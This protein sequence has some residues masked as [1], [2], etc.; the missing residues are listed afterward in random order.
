[1][2]ID[3]FHVLHKLLRKN[4]KRKMEK[5]LKNYKEQY[6]ENKMLFETVENSLVGWHGYAK[7]ANTYKYRKKIV[8]KIQND[9][10]NE[11]QLEK[12]KAILTEKK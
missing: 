4:N 8:E 12:I 1:M 5:K 7:Q 9:F 3:K 10:Q 6:D 2:L 11:P